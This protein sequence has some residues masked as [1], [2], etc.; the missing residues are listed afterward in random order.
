M[1]ARELT[2][3]EN[4]TIPEQ[5]VLFGRTDSDAVLKLPADGIYKL[6]R[7]MPVPAPKTNRRYQPDDEDSDSE[8]DILD[9]MRGE[10]IKIEKMNLN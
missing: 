8:P 9:L 7:Q 4:L 1:S 2:V 6:V 5:L 10:H 3:R